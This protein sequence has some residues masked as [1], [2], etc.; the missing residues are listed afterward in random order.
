MVWITRP[1]TALRA[2]R[3]EFLRSVSWERPWA[4]M[5][6][7]FTPNKGTPPTSKVSIFLLTRRRAGRASIAP[8]VENRLVF[9][10]VTKVDLDPMR[11]IKSV[12]RLESSGE[13]ITIYGKDNTMV[14]DIIN[15]LVKN[16]IDFRDLKTEQA[17]LEDV[18][19]TITGKE[20]R[21]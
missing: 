3:I 17:N 15:Y 16:D 11:K 13:K 14:K 12:S 19:L 2:D 20:I 10:I 1:S 4:M 8:I 7:P 5:T 21:T 9:N 18:F 6:T